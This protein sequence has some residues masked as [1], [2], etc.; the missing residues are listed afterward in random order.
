MLIGSLALI[1]FP[2]F[3]GFY[4][5][6]LIIMAAHESSLP[7]A[8]WAYYGVLG[9]VF[10]TAFYSFRLFFVVFHTKERMDE[11]TKSHIHESPAV[12]WLPLVL[13][14]IPSVVC[15]YLFVGDILGGYFGTSIDVSKHAVTGLLKEEFMLGGLNP[16]MHMAAHGLT[17]LPFILAMS[18]VFSAWICYVM[19]PSIPNKIKKVFHYLYLILVNKYGFDT[20][21]QGVL[22]GGI[23]GLGW[24]CWE[25]DK[26][27]IDGAANGAAQET[28]R[29]SKILRKVQTGYIYHYA[30]ALFLGLI[31]CL[32]WLLVRAS[33]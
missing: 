1:G 19:V 25:G 3:S 7:F 10:V 24:L 18:G 31:G 5:K 4:S 6:D 29:L 13:L 26:R 9:S 12:V 15:G 23:R 17:G 27:I 8:E 28:K 33:A 16:A 2:L 30:T 11:E 14:A 21:N 32:L 20:F 22:A